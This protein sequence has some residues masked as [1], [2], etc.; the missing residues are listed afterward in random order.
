MAILARLN[1]AGVDQKSYNTMIGEV[2]PRLRAA[3][4]F[5]AHIAVRQGDGFEVTEIWESNEALETWIRNVINPMMLN[6]G[7]IPPEV[8]RVPIHHYAIS[9]LI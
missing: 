6:A 8:N 3:P 7:G 4:G 5:V 1:Y 2:E 9:G